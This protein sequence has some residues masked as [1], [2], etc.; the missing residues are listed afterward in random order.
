MKNLY[1]DEIDF[2]RI[3]FRYDLVETNGFFRH[4]CFFL[5][6]KDNLMSCTM[7]ELLVW[8]AYGVKVMGDFRIIKTL[9][10]LHKHFY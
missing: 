9:K 1:P 3:Y 6:K 10:V 7:R 5:K 2:G 8:K 4:E